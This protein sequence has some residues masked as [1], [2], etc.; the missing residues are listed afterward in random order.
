VVTTAIGPLDL[1]IHGELDGRDRFVVGDVGTVRVGALTASSEGGA[2]RTRKHVRRSDPDLCKVDVLARGHGVVEQGGNEARLRPGDLAL[3]DLARPAY[4]TMSP[5]LIVA[6]V[7]PR[8]LLPLRSEE[9]AGRSAGSAERREIRPRLP[10][11]TAIAPTEIP[12]QSGIASP[13]SVNGPGTTPNC[14]SGAG[15]A[16]RVRTKPPASA[17]TEVIGPRCSRSHKAMFSGVASSQQVAGL[18]SAP[19]GQADRMVLEPAA[20]GGRVHDRVDAVAAQFGGPG[21]CRTAAG[22][23]RC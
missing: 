13:W 16:S 19:D 15:D 7:F 11:W 3:V 6:I 10:T 14:T 5:S 22:G 20:H 2:S 18:R 4:W 23:A 21:R 8:T 1:R 9:V 12:R 17:P